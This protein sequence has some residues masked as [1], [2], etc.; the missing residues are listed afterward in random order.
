M[1]KGLKPFFSF[2]GGKWRAAPH[3]P[4]PA[5][6]T[7]IE[8]FAGSAG[9]SL[10]Y[11]DRQVVLV[12]RDPVVAATWR[13][14]MTT[15]SAEILALPNVGYDQ[16]VDDLAVPQ[17][18]RWL[19]G[20]WLNKGTSAPAKTP[21]A[22]MRQGTHDNSYWGEV[23]KQR[24]AGQL[25]HIRHWRVIEGTYDNAPDIQAT[26]FIDPPYALAGKHYRFGAS[27]ID[28][29]CLADFCRSRQGQVMV[30]E[31]EGAAWLPFRPFMAIKA[32]EGRHGGKVSR[33]AIWP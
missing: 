27:T 20:W 28:Y 22:W 2:Y 17:E 11:P 31:N 9:Y 33:E 24:I 29:A 1:S 4:K 16:S 21:S 30:C 14:L 3:Y 25:E 8:P 7:I 26:W 18:A 12:E 5:F 15:T 23:I 19:I 10:R 13:Y 32:S 6:D